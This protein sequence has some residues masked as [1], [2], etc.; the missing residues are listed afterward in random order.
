MLYGVSN[1]NLK[2]FVTTDKD[3]LRN[4]SKMPL[5]Q[6]MISDEHR[7]SIKDLNISETMEFDDGDDITCDDWVIV[8]EPGSIL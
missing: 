2:D 5:K 7:K 6:F 4:V 3:I 1:P 8:K